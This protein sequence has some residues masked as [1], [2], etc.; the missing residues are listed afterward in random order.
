M[1]NGYYFL[2]IPEFSHADLRNLF[3]FLD[4]NKVGVVSRHQITLAM[5]YFKSE[6]SDRYDYK[7]PLA[8]ALKPLISTGQKVYTED[9][10]VYFCT[11]VTKPLTAGASPLDAT[12]KGLTTTFFDARN[13]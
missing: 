12:P 1:Q 4:F 6:F 8:Q 7:G 2:T 9:S 10:F 3:K 13:R 11:S 5:Q